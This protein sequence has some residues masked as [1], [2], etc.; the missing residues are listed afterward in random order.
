MR[1]VSPD[2]NLRSASRDPTQS[3]RKN[4]RHAGPRL[5][6][7]RD[8]RRSFPRRRRR[9]PHQYEP[10]F[11]RRHA[12]PGGDDSPARGRLRPADRHSRRPARPQAA[13][14]RVRRRGRGAAQ[15]RH[16]PPRCGSDAGD[17]EP[18]L[19]AAP[20]DSR[21]ARSRPSRTDRRRQGVAAG[22]GGCAKCTPTASSRSPEKSPTRRG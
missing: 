1:F 20:R 13:R 10:R 22:H 12:R 17:R 4:H 2:A 16:F 19:P 8:R 6:R 15:G 18:R 7:L 5:G 14:R 21:V 3:P 9:L 11:P